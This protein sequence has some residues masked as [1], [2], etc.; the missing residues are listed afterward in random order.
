MKSINLSFII[1]FGIQMLSCVNVKEFEEQQALFVPEE[2]SIQSL[3]VR[4]DFDYSTTKEIDVVLDVPQFLKSAVFKIFEK[5]G[6]QDSTAVG[7]ATFD[8]NGHFEK[9]FKVKAT[10]DSI[11]LFSD[12]V[13]LIKDLSLPIDGGAVTFDYRT[14]YQRTSPSGKKAIRPLKF[15]SAED[16]GLSF[17][18]M[19]TFDEKEGVPDYLTT[20][21]EITQEF[22]DDINASIPDNSD[23]TSQTN[24]AYLMEAD[25][26]VILTEEAEVW[27]TFVSEGAKKENA[28]GYYSY[29]LDNPP[30]RPEDI[31]SLTIIFP[32]ASLVKSSGGLLPGD[33]VSLGSFPANTVVAWFLVRD[34]FDK[35]EVK[36]DKDIYFS[37]PDFNTDEDYEIPY[38]T[39]VLYNEA[40]KLALL[41]FED[42]EKKKDPN[43][44]N[45][46]VF[47]VKS[48]PE[49]ALQINNVTIMLI[50][51]DEDGDGIEDELDSYPADPNKAFNNFAPSETTTGKLVYEDLWPSK[52]DYDFNDLSMDYR[53]NLITNANNLVTSLEAK[54]T[55]ENIGGSLQNGF[56]ISLPIDPQNISGIEGQLLNGDYETVAANGTELDSAPNESIILVIGNVASLEGTVINMTINF[57][58]PLNAE[59]LGDIPFNPF[60]IVNGDRVREVHLPNFPP[61][62]KADYL[63]TFD[64]RTNLETGFY[65]KT[66][67]NLPWA[68]HIYDDTFVVPIESIPITQQYPDFV[69]WANSSGQNKKDWYKRK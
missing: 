33:R 49:N 45:D 26:Q 37:N 28:L 44:Y 3:N 58:S 50:A 46:V 55:I 30:S 27:V 63:G 32:N 24:P 11:I 38:F 36:D 41:G 8:T 34:G 7:R 21:D 60:L 67:T 68:L 6:N 14:V 2:G 52:G 10:A 56:G 1:L 65:Y 69:E 9:R 64:D 29:P 35:D 51:N 40:N 42:L 31:E 12:Y 18:Y 66:N 20:P 62:S 48:S 43:D 13:G 39:V 22:L 54:F 5:A 25:A 16:F 4:A 61:T 23:G 15:E 47:Y 19:G 53:Y 17:T 59:V 57:D